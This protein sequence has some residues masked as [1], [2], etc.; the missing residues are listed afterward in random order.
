MNIKMH[1]L[2]VKMSIRFATINAGTKINMITKEQLIN[3]K[4]TFEIISYKHERL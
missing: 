4:I 3:D 1:I 2:Q